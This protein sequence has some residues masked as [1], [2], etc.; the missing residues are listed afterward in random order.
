MGLRFRKSI[1]LIPGVRVNLG[2]KGVCLSVGPRG[3]SVNASSRGVYGNVGIPGSGISYRTRLNNSAQGNNFQARSQSETSTASVNIFINDTGVVEAFDESGVRLPPRYVKAAE[4]Q[5]PDV[6]QAFLTQQKDKINTLTQKLTGLVLAIPEPKYRST[7]ID[8]PF[9]LQIPHKEQN[10]VL[11]PEQPKGPSRPQVSWIDNGI[12]FFRTRKAK[13]Y[14]RNKEEYLQAL[15]DWKN[16]QEKHQREQSRIE[17]AHQE[18][19]ARYQAEENAHNAETQ[20]LQNKREQ[21]LKENTDTMYEVFEDAVHEIDWPRETRIS[22]N[23]SSCGKQ[24]YIDVDLPEIEDFPAREACISGS[25]LRIKKVTATQQRSMYAHHI[26]SIGL[27]LCG[28]GFNR[29]P[30]TRQVVVSGL[31]QRKDN[32]TGYINDEYLYSCNMTR[33]QFSQLSFAN[34]AELNPMAALGLGELRCKMSKTHILKPIEPFSEQE[35]IVQ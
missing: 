19:M 13:Q 16:L 14:E 22:F 5:N 23:F 12:S 32:R 30:T 1:T 27:L 20:A 18:Q 6:Y 2:L 34:L 33:R 21:L 10:P 35:Q 17:Q 24:L 29:L 26:G 15:A 8:R 9:T 25:R 11:L 7:L 3:V 31:S 4:Q 28:I